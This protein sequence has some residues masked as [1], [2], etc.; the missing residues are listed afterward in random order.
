M[1]IT[2]QNAQQTLSNGSEHVDWLSLAVRIR[3]EY[4]AFEYHLKLIKASAYL[5]STGRFTT[6]F[7]ESSIKLNTFLRQVECGLFRFGKMVNRT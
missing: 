6:F 1:L 5:K 3:L 7:F 2:E 4:S